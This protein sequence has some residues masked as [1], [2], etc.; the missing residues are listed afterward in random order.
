MI[1][2]LLIYGGICLAIGGGLGAYFHW[3]ISA[4]RKDD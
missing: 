3:L 2:F 1:E 4:V